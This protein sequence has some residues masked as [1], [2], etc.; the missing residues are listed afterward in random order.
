MGGRIRMGTG[1]SKSHVLHT[2]HAHTK[3]TKSVS[4]HSTPG[5]EHRSRLQPGQYAQ[6]VCFMS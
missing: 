2:P 1:M 6:H 5:V 4:S 3:R